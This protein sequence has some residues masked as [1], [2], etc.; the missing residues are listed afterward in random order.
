VTLTLVNFVSSGTDNEEEEID[1]D[2]CYISNKK[3]TLS[4]T[5]AETMLSKCIECFEGQEEA[6]ARSYFSYVKYGTWPLRVHEPR[7]SKRK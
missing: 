6:N 5:E 7:R 3:T 2:E 1:K 4:H